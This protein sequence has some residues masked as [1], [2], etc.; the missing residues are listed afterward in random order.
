MRAA[1]TLWLGTIGLCAL[2]CA[3]PARA[4]DPA[5]APVPDA[6]QPQPLPP[7]APQPSAP[8]LLSFTVS[9]GVS[10]GSYEAGTLYFLTE[11]IKRSQGEYELKIATGASAGSANA[12]IALIDSCRPQVADPT[13]SLGYQTWLPVGIAQLFVPERVTP[14]SVL[15]RG[16]LV[17]AMERLAERVRAEGLPTSCDLVFG[18]SVTRK[19]P[20]RVPIRDRALSSAL[21]V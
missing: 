1:R 8:H 16:P 9:G 3:A 13:Y 14:I 19:V 17:G 21:D 10:L 12:L 18:V 7:S 11:S 2:A 4:Q 15:N 5:V 20:A 6:A